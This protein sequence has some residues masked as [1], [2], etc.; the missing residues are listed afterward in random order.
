MIMQIIHLQNHQYSNN[1]KRPSRLFLYTIHIYVTT[2]KQRGYHLENE[3]SWLKESI[4]EVLE[5]EK[6]WGKVM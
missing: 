4:L 5:G 2:V 3:N 6:Q 1:R